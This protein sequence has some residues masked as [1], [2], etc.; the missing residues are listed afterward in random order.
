LGWLDHQKTH[1]KC[2][3]SLGRRVFLR[4]VHNSKVLLGFFVC[5][6]VYWCT[7]IDCFKKLRKIIVEFGKKKPWSCRNMPKY[8]SRKKT[9]PVLQKKPPVFCAKK[10]KTFPPKKALHGWAD[11][12]CHG[13]LIKLKNE[14][15]NFGDTNKMLAIKH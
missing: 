15:Y 14:I 9:S 10:P 4:H 11:G 8:D 7:I 6:I 3:C 5:S 1:S 2:R 12:T 13:S